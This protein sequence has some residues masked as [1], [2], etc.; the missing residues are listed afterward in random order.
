MVPNRMARASSK[1]EKRWAQGGISMAGATAHAATTAGQLGTAWAAMQRISEAKIASRIM[2]SN[3]CSRMD[4]EFREVLLLLD[5][6][7]T[8]ASA[9]CSGLHLWC[10]KAQ[11]ACQWGKYSRA[12]TAGMC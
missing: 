11:W 2:P 10:G 4:V 1:R 9:A 5:D 7:K 8:L 3:R 12:G 6:E